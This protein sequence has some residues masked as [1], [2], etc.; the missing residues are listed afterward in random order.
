MNSVIRVSRAESMCGGQRQENGKGVFRAITLI[1]SIAP[2]LCFFPL[3]WFHP[4]PM[5]RIKGTRKLRSRK[6]N[7]N[8]A[9]GTA[10]TVILKG[11]GRKTLPGKLPFYISKIASVI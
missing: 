10:S 9:L 6:E 7:K 5:G 4:C 1:H 8:E 11:Q 2:L 3:P